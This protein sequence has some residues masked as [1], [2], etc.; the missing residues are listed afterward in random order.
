MSDFK[1]KKHKN[2]FPL[3][4]RPTPAGGVYSAFPDHLAVFKGPTFKGRA[5]EERWEWKGR[6]REEE[7]K[8]RK[9]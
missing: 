2:R 1:A 6:E 5:G 4:L 7:D 3:G 9:R 8:R